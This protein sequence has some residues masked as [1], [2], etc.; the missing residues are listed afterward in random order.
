MVFLV[1]LFYYA[2]VP[3]HLY[4]HTMFRDLYFLPL[5]LAGIW[6]GLRAAVLTSLTVTAL[7]MPFVIMNWGGFSAIDFRRL[8]EAVVLIGV[9]VTLGLISEREK[10]AQQSLRESAS[11]IAMGKALSAA[12]HDMKSPLTAIG[13]FARLVHKRLKEDDQSRQ[14]LA[15]VIKETDRLE[16]MARDM[17]DFSRPLKLDLTHGDLN[18]FLR[19]T[20]VIVDFQAREKN[21]ALEAEFSASLPYVEFDILRMEQVFIN[22]VVNA[23]Q[24]SPKGEK[25]LIRTY[26]GGGR[27]YIEVVDHGPGI[28][29]QDREKIF[30]PFFTTK[31]EGTGLG[32][33]IALKV[34]NA[35]GG[36][37]E[38]LQTSEK[39]AALRVGLPLKRL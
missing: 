21:V 36:T 2:T 30:S 6:F 28:P 26:Q 4:Y 19:E 15:I 39:G 23:L 31:K 3:G 20:L 7:Y 12:A 1:S 25:V 34:L 33:P 10:R 11:L 5:V 35:H 29:V 22:L 8:M 17:L 38:V 16:A 37:L 32:L 14:M 13:G 27:V 18:E 24:A 9:A